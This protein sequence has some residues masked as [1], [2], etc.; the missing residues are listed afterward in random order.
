MARVDVGTSVEICRESIGE[1][2]AEEARIKTMD[3]FVSHEKD[4]ILYQSMV[5]SH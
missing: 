4:F 2:I 5:Q 1:E 3:Y